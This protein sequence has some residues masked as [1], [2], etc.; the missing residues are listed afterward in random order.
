MVA[1]GRMRGNSFPANLTHR[2]FAPFTQDAKFP[3]K[4][5]KQFLSKGFLRTLC[6]FAVKWLVFF[7]VSFRKWTG[8]EHPE[9][10]EVLCGWLSWI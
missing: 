4:F 8:Y 5:Q 10:M 2:P 9:R 6:V 7:R 3:K 1:E